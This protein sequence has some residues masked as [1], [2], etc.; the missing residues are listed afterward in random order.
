MVVTYRNYLTQ[1]AD[2]Q[3]PGKQGKN[4]RGSTAV[5]IYSQ[6]CKFLSWHGVFNFDIQF[7][8]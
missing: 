6:T 3:M 4:N 7:Q 5:V 2:N 1:R 8:N